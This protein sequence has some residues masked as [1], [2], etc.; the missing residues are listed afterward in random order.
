VDHAAKHAA[1]EAATWEIRLNRFFT[2]D[3]LVGAERYEM[4]HKKLPPRRPWRLDESIWAPRPKMSESKDFWD[5]PTCKRKALETCW[6]RALGCGIGR[7]ILRMDDGNDNAKV[8]E[9]FAVLW[10]FHD[11][12]FALFDF[13]SA[14]GSSNDI[15]HMQMNAFSTFL[16]D[17][18]LRVKQHATIFKVVDASSAGGKT[19]ETCNR[20]NALNL[21]EFIQAI[22]QVSCTMHV[23]SGAI[24]DVSDAVHHMFSTDIEP[25]LDPN[26]FCE[27]NEFRS[28]HA[29]T[30]EVDMVLR[31]FEASLRLIY[32]SACRHGQSLEKGEHNYLVSYDAWKD[33][34]RL[35]GLIDVDVSDRDVTL[36]F[37]FSRMRIVDDQN[38][39]SRVRLTYLGFEDFL[40]GLCRL[41]VRKSLPTDDEIAAAGRASAGDFLWCLREEQPAEYEDLLRKRALSWGTEPPQPFARCVAHFCSLLVVT[42]QRNKGDG[43]QL[44]QR[45]VNAFMKARP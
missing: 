27:P 29:Y 20:K 45:Q 30:E 18:R 3:E 21:Q 36:A 23:E 41:S 40:E 8:D 9:V 1:F 26:V 22:I 2:V 17:C 42:C 24:V 5:T 6:K 16:F 28:A 10:E 31:T 12:I 38:E 43:V 34:W 44:T 11:L 33:I 19:D 25:R 4:R 37:V 14:I 35:Y 7:Y 15:T 39:R 32:E 13:Y